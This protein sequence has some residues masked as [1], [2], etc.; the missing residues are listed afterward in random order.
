MENTPG[1]DLPVLDNMNQILN[2]LRNLLDHLNTPMLIE[3]ASKAAR[4]NVEELI[5]SYRNQVDNALS[6]KLN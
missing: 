4:L 5:K 3:C 2:Q 6:K 1:I